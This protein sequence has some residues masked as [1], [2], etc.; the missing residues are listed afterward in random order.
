LSHGDVIAKPDV[1]SFDGLRATFADGSSG[2]FDLV[3]L[4]TGYRKA[5]P[6]LPESL[7]REGDV[8]PLFL[9]VFHRQHPTLSVVSFFETD[10]G[11]FP[12]I[13]R[14][15]ELI[16]KTWRARRESPAKLASF[17][18]AV[19]GPPPDLGGG[20]RYLAVER[21]ANYVRMRPYVEYVEGLARA[22]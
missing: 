12:V 13:D 5:L 10:G 1:R 6:L 22:L 11:S 8:S 20:V 21:M 4:A 2:D 14:Q 18:A 3:V 17:T 7:F 16:A 19:S 15:C 9:N